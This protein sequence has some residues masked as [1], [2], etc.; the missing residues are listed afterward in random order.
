MDQNRQDEEAAAVV[1]AGRAEPAITL[2]DAGRLI[3]MC[4][5]ANYFHEKVGMAL[6][7][8]MELVAMCSSEEQKKQAIADLASSLLRH[9][10]A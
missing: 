8:S 6:R 3:D 4:V 2:A 5:S 10:R 9:K 1:S 7:K